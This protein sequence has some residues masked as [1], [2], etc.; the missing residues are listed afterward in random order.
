MGTDQLS[1]E[2][3]CSAEAISPC[4]KGPV[5]F[6]RFPV[7][8]FVGFGVLLAWINR[9]VQDDAYISFRYARNLADGFGLV[10]NI[11]ERVEGYTNFLWTLLMVPAFWLGCDVVVWCQVL[12][13]LSYVATLLLVWKLSGNGKTEQTPFR[14]LPL[15]LIATNFSIT[16]YATGGLETQFVTMLAVLAAYLSEKSLD[17]KWRQPLL[18]SL[19]S[20]AAILT[21]MDSVLLIAPFWLYALWRLL[22]GQRNSATPSCKRLII[23]GLITS[24]LVGAWLAWRHAYYGF[25]LPNTFLIKGESNPLR[26]LCYLL[27]FFILYGWFV[28]PAISLWTYFQRKRDA[29]PSLREGGL[30]LPLRCA[31]FL[32]FA[33]VILV[34]GDFMEFRM[35]M[36][37]VP[38]ASLLILET[39]Q[40]A[41]RKIR[42]GLL[43]GILFLVVLVGLVGIPRWWPVKLIQPL[44]ELKSMAAEWVQSSHDLNRILGQE[45]SDVKIAVSPAGILP[46][47]TR[48]PSFDNLGLNTREVALAGDRIPKPPRSRFGNLPGHVMMA[49]WNQLEEAD[50]HLL[51]NNPWI[52]P[53]ASRET[54]FESL[55]LDANGTVDT[56]A[57]NLVF[58]GFHVTVPNT[59]TAKLLVWNLPNGNAWFM[60]YLAPH[61]LVEKALT[62]L[63][64]TYPLR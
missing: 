5:L 3:G 4:E 13:M 46:F 45:G 6:S 30:V 47:L 11:G 50:V 37:A 48:L 39:V 53:K 64:K 43:K 35:V 29:V 58:P 52:V 41:E 17:G 12:S 14:F 62:T 32:W 28:F 61:P 21:R 36:P 59:T 18:L 31:V 51:I 42:A 26:G 40:A 22:S 60:L 15:L 24:V 9:F 44:W 54:V 23:G 10:W 27:L 55:K 63:G 8:I 49:K 7:W 2:S 57:L 20:A 25:W 33:Y 16:S 56:Q 19:V 34:G 1:Q 38:F